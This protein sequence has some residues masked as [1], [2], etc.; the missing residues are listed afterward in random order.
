M[1][2]ILREQAQWRKG[3]TPLVGKYLTEH[4]KVFDAIAGRGFLN[5]PGFAYD[6]ENGLEMALKQ[7]LSELNYK[8]LAETIEREMKQAGIDY[9]TAYATAA[10]AW[11]SEKQSLMAAWDAELS[12]IKQGMA[13]EEEVKSRL[14]LEVDARQAVLIAAKTSIETQMES[15]RAQLAA[16]DDDTADY[17]VSLANA[18]LLTAQKKL[19]LIPIMQ[20]ILTKEGELLDLKESKTAYYKTFLDAEQEVATKKNQL[21]PSLSQL[22][23]KIQQHADAI[24]GQVTTEQAIAAEKIAQAEAKVEVADN[25]VD[26]LT[27]DIATENKRVDIDEARRDLTDKQFKKTTALTSLEIN[28]ETEYQ[29]NLNDA[30]TTLNDDARNTSASLINLGRQ[31]NDVR[32]DD[33]YQSVVTLNDADKD[34]HAAIAA[35]K[36]Y[37]TREIANLTAAKAITASLTHLIG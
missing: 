17:E 32:N 14:S 31:T 15:Y 36:R 27:L 33:S 18:K 24:L 5:L 30:F 2:E 23:T 22:A 26:R 35:A 4:R 37:E 28:N 11:E 13:Q 3:K 20:E 12:G 1:S 7:N 6:M 19:E 16:L 8:I 29:N 10:L 25:E 9:D 21:I 34:A